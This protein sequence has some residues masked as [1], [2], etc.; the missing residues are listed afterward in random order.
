MFAE[1]RIIGATHADCC[2][3]LANQLPSGDN[4]EMRVKIN[5]F[6]L[7]DLRRFLAERGLLNQLET[8]I[9]SSQDRKTFLLKIEEYLNTPT[10]GRLIAENYI[11][12]SLV[13]VAQPACPS[14]FENVDPND[15]YRGSKIF[16]HLRHH[17]IQ[18]AGIDY[19]NHRSNTGNSPRRSSPPLYGCGTFTRFFLIK[20]FGPL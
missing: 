15:P 18:R 2:S 5:E 12:N 14:V 4:V 3:V 17:F 1:G 11:Y 20:F 8:S 16:D 7:E 9:L 6:S 19:Y 10:P 13:L